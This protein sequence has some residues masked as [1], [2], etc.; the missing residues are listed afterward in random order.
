[1]ASMV[2]AGTS[3]L[4]SWAMDFSWVLLIICDVDFCH[5]NTSVDGTMHDIV[6]NSGVKETDL[7]YQAFVH[8]ME[9]RTST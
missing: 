9:V 5:D 3:S 1:M 2:N 6:I 8:Y 4:F 7:T